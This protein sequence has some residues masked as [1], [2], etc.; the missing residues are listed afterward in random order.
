[1]SVYMIIEIAI[2]DTAMYGQ[3]IGQAKDI[4]LKYG[5]K[6]HVRGGRIESMFGSWKPERLIVIEFDSFETVERCFGSKEYRAIAHLRENS[7]D[8][9]AVVVEAYASPV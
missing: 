7:T 8:S 9:R 2:H 4:I 3:Y 6:Y 1:M 5:G